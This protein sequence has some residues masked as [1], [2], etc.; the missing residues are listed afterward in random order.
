MDLAPPS[1]LG[2]TPVRLGMEAAN[3][4]TLWQGTS[5]DLHTRRMRTGVSRDMGKPQ[6]CHLEGSRQRYALTAAV[7]LAG[8]IPG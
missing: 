3:Q 7:L 6:G 2:W 4:P 5:R 8:D 1:L